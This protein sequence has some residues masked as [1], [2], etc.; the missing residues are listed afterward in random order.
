MKIYLLL[1]SYGIAGLG[2]AGIY[3]TKKEK[4]VYPV[5]LALT[6]VGMVC[7]YLLEYEVSNAGNFT[8]GNIIAYIAIIPAFTVLT[9]HFI[10]KYLV[11]K[12]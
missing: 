5:V 12:K 9:Y 3:G 6:V 1:V 8:T 10:V 4:V 7:R 11:S 2:F